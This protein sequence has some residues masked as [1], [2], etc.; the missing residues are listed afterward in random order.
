MATAGTWVLLLLTSPGA[1]SRGRTALPRRALSPSHPHVAFKLDCH[2]QVLAL[3]RCRM[4]PLATNCS[5]FEGAAVSAADVACWRKFAGYHQAVGLAMLSA[6]L[7]R[8]AAHHFSTAAVALAGAI[9]VSKAAEWEETRQLALLMAACSAL[10]PHMPLQTDRLLRFVNR[11]SASPSLPLPPLKRRLCEPVRPAPKA[12]QQL[13]FSPFVAATTTL[14]QG[15]EGGGWTAF[16]EGAGLDA[17]VALLTSASREGRSRGAK[18]FRME[19]LVAWMRD[20]GIV[21]PMVL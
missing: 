17:A 11:L 16:I 9:A 20:S 2:R 13:L 19:R 14:G 3:L 7:P 6:S 5:V 10:V 18:L 12:S 15:R 8:E 4:P 1:T 21:M